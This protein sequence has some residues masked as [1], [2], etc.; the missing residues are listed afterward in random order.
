MR[1]AIE[2]ISDSM[3]EDITRVG[4][5]AYHTHSMSAVVLKKAAAKIVQIMTLDW[6]EDT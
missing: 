1:N 3:L 5:L 6:P 4:L 2:R